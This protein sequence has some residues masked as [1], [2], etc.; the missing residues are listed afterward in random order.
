MV[1]STVIFYDK[2]AYEFY[3]NT[4]NVDMSEHYR[5]FEEYLLPE[6]SILDAG[7]GSGRDSLYFLSK[8]Y[9]VSAFDASVEMVKLSSK[10]TG[11]TVQHAKFE[12]LNFNLV[13]N[14][15]WASASLL[16]VDRGTI[17]DILKKL[18]AMLDKGGVLF[19]SFKYG[20]K[21]YKKDDRLFNCYDE[22]SFSEM[23]SSIPELTILELYR[24]AD[25]REERTN[26]FW[27][28]A[29]VKKA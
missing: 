15:I 7:C 2:N 4:V 9:K 26:E 28:S 23:F 11:L 13:F 6:S 1:N 16:H 19:M 27:L 3:N 24:T 8:G 20:D 12:D 21:V 10:L 5:R 17:I 22:S 14:G 25:V 29:I 18:T